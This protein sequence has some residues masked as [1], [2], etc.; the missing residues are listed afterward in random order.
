MEEQS[1]SG[2]SPEG[3]ALGREIAAARVRK[4]WSQQR[5]AQETGVSQSS[6]K[7][8]ETGKRVPT[9]T[10]LIVLGRALG[11]SAGDMLDIAAEA[12]EQD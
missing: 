2:A 11:I 9:V 6:L 10:T 1:Q 7:H 4:G 12:M 8:Y 3:R 5:L